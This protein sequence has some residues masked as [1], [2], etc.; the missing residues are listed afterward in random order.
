[1]RDGIEEALGSI[2]VSE[3]EENIKG[4]EDE[5]ERVAMKKEMS[6]IPLPLHTTTKANHTRIL[7]TVH[8]NQQARQAPPIHAGGSGGNG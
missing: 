2:S 4:S 6:E 7:V 3:V 1:M 8:D 5:A